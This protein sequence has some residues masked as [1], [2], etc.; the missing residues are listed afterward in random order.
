[1]PKLAATKHPEQAGQAQPEA[2]DDAS[3]TDSNETLAEPQPKRAPQIRPSTAADLKPRDD[4]GA[5]SSE[6]DEQDAAQTPLDAN[7]TSPAD[8]KADKPS[9]K[10]PPART[11]AD[12]DRAPAGPPRAI[13]L[14][15]VGDT[16]FASSGAPVHP[17]FGIRS[18]ARY[19]YESMSNGIRGLIDGDINFSNLETVVTASNGL[20]PLAKAFNFRTHPNG[21]RHLIDLGFNLFSLAN[22]HAI[23]YGRQGVVATLDAMAQMPASR[24][25]ASAGLGRTYEDAM[26]PRVFSTKGA[27]FAFAAIGIGSGGARS[28][29]RPGPDR[30]GQ[31]SY[32]SS[33]DYPELSRRLGAVPDAY[34]ILSAHTGIER[35]V[36]PLQRDVRRFRDVSIGRDDIDLVIAHHAHVVQGLQ[37]RNNKLVMY[38]LGNF[39]HPGMANMGRFGRCR[40]YGLVVKV[41]LAHWPGSRPRLAAVEAVAITNMHVSPRPLSASAGAQ[42]IAVLNGLA[43]GLDNTETGATGVRFHSRPDGTGLH[44][45]QHGAKLP[46]AIGAACRRLGEPT[47]ANTTAIG[48]GR[49]VRRPSSANPSRRRLTRRQRRTRVRNAASRPRPDQSWKRRA[50][51]F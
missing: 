13:T 43:R 47:S 20:R 6:P 2:A 9:A 37:V 42:R 3:K 27:R 33:A 45:T 39:L 17:K 34:R 51:G 5:G 10:S 11:A 31:L 26:T 29:L 32:S 22:N 40:D 35:S 36:T 28:A 18:G 30:A 41:H 44:C 23:D 7:A 50:L 14:V 8:A 48:C 49:Y 12:N 19:P 24:V 1:M 25:L 15:A 21:V 38:G 16:G 46:G 4:E